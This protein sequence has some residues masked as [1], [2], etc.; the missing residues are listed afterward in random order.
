MTLE[1]IQNSIIIIINKDGS[2]YVKIPSN[3][4]L[5]FS[6]KAYADMVNTLAVI[7][8]P[9]YFIRAMLWIERKLQSLSRSIT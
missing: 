5:E 1:E 6:Q 7:G 8:E 2:N 4:S 9:S 3:D